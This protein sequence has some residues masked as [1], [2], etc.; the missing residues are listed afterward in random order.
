MDWLLFHFIESRREPSFTPSN[1][2]IGLGLLEFSADLHPMDDRTQAPPR[3]RQ[4]C[5]G[6]TSRRAILLRNDRA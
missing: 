2:T 3:S 5:V 1:Q 6:F 4:S